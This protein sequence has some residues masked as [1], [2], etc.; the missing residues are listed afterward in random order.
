MS[1]CPTTYWC[2]DGVPTP[3]TTDEETGITSPPEGAE[4]GPFATEAEAA[5]V[6]EIPCPDG[7]CGGTQTLS[8]TCVA[9]FANKT[10][11]ATCLPNSV[12]MVYGPIVAFQQWCTSGSFGNGW[13][14]P[15]V[16]VPG[17]PFPDFSAGTL[18]DVYLNFNVTP[19]VG[20]E[21][22]RLDATSCAFNNSQGYYFDMDF[23]W[24]FCTDGPITGPIGPFAATMYDSGG[25]VGT[26]DIYLDFGV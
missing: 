24:D 1:C 12:E 8:S 26:F 13:H 11:D 3:G 4:S 9:T 17:F 16:E 21:A 25:A 5:C 19:V 2:V 15:S 20:G 6:V 10:G 7:E 14:L 18:C 23:S 22:C